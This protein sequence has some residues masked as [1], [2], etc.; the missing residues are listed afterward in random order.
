MTFDEWITWLQSERHKGNPLIDSL[1]ACFDKQDDEAKAK[2]PKAEPAS[3]MAADTE[4]VG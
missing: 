4:P 3:V 2:A 1:L